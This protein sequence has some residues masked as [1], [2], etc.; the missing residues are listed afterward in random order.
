M[1]PAGELLLAPVL[2]YP[3]DAEIGKTYLFTVDLRTAES[4]ATWPYPQNE[5]VTIYCFVDASPLFRCHA[6]GE[7][8]VVLHRFGGT[9]GPARFLLTPEPV[10]MDGIIRVTLANGSGVP[11]G[12][13]ETGEIRVRARVERHAEPGPIFLDNQNLPGG[14]NWRATLHGDP[15]EALLIAY[16]ENVRATRY[17]G[18]PALAA[19]QPLLEAIGP[20]VQPPMRFDASA[21][22]PNGWAEQ[23]GYKARRGTI[24]FMP[25]GDDAWVRSPEP[26]P[27]SGT[28]LLPML[29]TNLYAFEL[30]TRAPGEALKRAATYQLAGSESEF[31][32]TMERPNELAARHAAPF[33]AFLRQ[34]LIYDARGAKDDYALVVGIERYREFEPLRSAVED[35]RAVAAWLA[36][37]AGGAL[38]VDQVT[39]LDSPSLSEFEKT[40]GSVVEPGRRESKG[41]RFYLYLAG[42][43][44]SNDQV[45]STNEVL[46]LMPEASPAIM[47]L[48]IAARAYL[49]WL[50]LQR[51]FEEIVL[52]CDCSRVPSQSISPR[53]PPFSEPKQ[54]NALKVSSVALL[55]A[56]P[57]RRGALTHA[58]LAG[59]RG[60][61]ATRDG[62][63][64]TQ[65]LGSYL[66][67]RI[68]IGDRLSTLPTMLQSGD[69]LVFR[70]NVPPMLVRVRISVPRSRFG[71]LS[72]QD[73][74]QRAILELVAG[75]E[76]VEVQLRPG[77]YAVEHVPSH[78]RMLF[79][80]NPSNEVVEFAPFGPPE[81]LGTTATPASP[82]DDLKVFENSEYA[83]WLST[84][85]EFIRGG[86]A[87]GDSRE[88]PLFRAAMADLRAEIDGGAPLPIEAACSSR[89]R[90]SARSNDHS[91][92]SASE[93]DPQWT[94]IAD[95]YR[96]L[97]VRR[98]SIPYRRSFKDVTIQIPDSARIALLAGWGTGTAGAGEVLQQVARIS[99][100]FAIHL[101]GIYYSGTPF[102]VENRFYKPWTSILPPGKIRSFALCGEHELYSGGEAYYEM[103]GRIQQPESHF[104]L[105][106]TNWQIVAID[107]ALNS[108]GSQSTTFL[109]GDELE[110]LRRQIS[111][112]SGRR[113]LLLSYHHLFSSIPGYQLNRTLLDQ[114][115]PQLP[116][117]T[118]WFWADE[119]SVRIYQPYMGVHA[120][121]VGNSGVPVAAGESPIQTNLET[122]VLFVNHGRS[123]ELA[124]L[125]YT[126]L[127]LNGSS[128]QVSY[129]ENQEGA[130]LEV[131]R[132]LLG[133]AFST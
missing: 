43:C 111:M 12:V 61:A 19:L 65:S 103:I 118:A 130:A 108:L 31:W 68:N 75:H 46:V 54:F 45:V 77:L 55:S 21:G 51:R 95:R 39:L 24:R 120:R 123:G 7:P 6:F 115:G 116:F 15:D 79:E 132:E 27:S 129:Y 105:Q 25:P 124:N 97:L 60:E 20:T 17:G 113:T 34:A 100:D 47:G 4:R 84:V 86:V 91:L 109:D 126:M 71:Q 9:Y 62:L 70:E 5:E 80:V 131:Y 28:D 99:P 73:D 3:R 11:L 8:A 85:E 18:Q 69:G 63:I 82:T 37:P 107:T 30:I 16:L 44:V 92:L 29:L 125:T 78:T 76:P 36:D 101:G 66:M 10:E 106:N 57:E 23:S 52:I 96:G 127:Q 50:E 32:A 104:C 14:A 13:I 90:R 112:E 53:L 87:L 33:T 128:A 117:I 133:A 88:D 64:T 74:A 119:L 35:A 56:G 59:L 38:P 2:G 22:G 98:R 67:D 58:L 93:C 40:V 48:H 89:A 110:W 49:H 81:P 1:T 114:L 122:P 42:R 26:Q 41:R 102:E 94:K 83:L 121:C 72:I